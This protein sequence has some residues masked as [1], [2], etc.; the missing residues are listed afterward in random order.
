MLKN[1]HFEAKTITIKPRKCS[2]TKKKRAK[3]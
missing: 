3:S 1:R 2:K